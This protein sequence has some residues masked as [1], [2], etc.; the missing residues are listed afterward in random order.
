MFDGEGQDITLPANS[1]L[2]SYQYRI[3]ALMG[4]GRVTFGGTVGGTAFGVLQN[5]PS[6]QDQPARVRIAGWTKIQTN[7][8]VSAGVLLTS[9]VQG[10]GVAAGTAGHFCIVL[11][12]RANGGSGD[13]TSGLVVHMN[14]V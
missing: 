7:A 11:T 6:A 13:I 2:S 14:S 8:A 5:K 10:F 3:V 9:T 12:A 1:D 4:D